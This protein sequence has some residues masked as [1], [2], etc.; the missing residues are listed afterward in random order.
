MSQAALIVTHGSPSDPEGQE[1][2]LSDLAAKVA[3]QLP[4]WTVSSATLA[5]GTRL[6]EQVE[7]LGR[8]LVYPFF[9]AAGWFT[10]TVL[11]KRLSG[12]GLS[13]MTPFGVEPALLNV[14]A[15]RVEKTLVEQGWN[16]RDTAL[17]VAAHGSARSKQSANAARDFTAG[18]QAQF[19]F[20]EVRTGFVE[21]DPRLEPTLDQAGQAICLPFFATN[22]GHM[23]EDVPDA[24][25]ETK[26]AGVVLPAFIDWPETVDLIAQSLRA[27]V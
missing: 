16:A 12:F 14:A 23:M 8:P 6:E 1:R 18:M 9:M 3:A 4:D 24:L 22:A 26:F 25:A 7:A 27:S 10:Q 11:P 17:I 19:G 15:T 20:R 5:A 21:Q 13:A 2:D